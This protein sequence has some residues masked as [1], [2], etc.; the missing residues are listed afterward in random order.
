MGERLPRSSMEECLSY[1][2][3]VAGSSPAAA[4][5]MIRWL[6]QQAK[7]PAENRKSSV[8]FGDQRLER[9][10]GARRTWPLFDKSRA[11]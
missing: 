2:Q 5:G 3:E 8:R 4:I 9:E 10:A 11:D 6:A 1:T 7:R